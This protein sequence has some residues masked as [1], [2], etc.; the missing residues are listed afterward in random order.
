VGG[1]KRKK[2]QE[3]RAGLGVVREGRKG[4]FME[5]RKTVRHLTFTDSRK[6]GEKKKGGGSIFEG[7]EEKKGTDLFS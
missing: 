2:K 5:K 4:G 7:K 1:K 6:K 3:T